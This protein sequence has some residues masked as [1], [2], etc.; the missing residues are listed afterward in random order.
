M[1][2]RN[3]RDVMIARHE[4]EEKGKKTER[5]DMGGSSLNAK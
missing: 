2:K 1:C 5:G 3:V 4:S